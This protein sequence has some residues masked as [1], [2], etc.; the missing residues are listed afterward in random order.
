MVGH[1]ATLVRVLAAVAAI[2][3]VACSDNND[4]VG[5]DRPATGLH[6]SAS[7]GSTGSGL[8]SADLQITGS[9][10][11]GSPFTDSLFTYTLQIKNSGPDDAS[12]ATI[13][14]TLPPSVTFA[15]IG[16]VN[17]SGTPL[18]TQTPTTTSVVASCD[19]GVLR[20]GA[21]ASMQVNIYAPDGAGP[22]SNTA[23]AISSLPDPVLSNNSVAITV[24]AQVAKPAKV[25][26]VP[27][28]G[29]VAT[30]AFTTLPAEQFGGYVFAGGPS[31]VGFQF[32]PT[33][34]GTLAELIVATEASGG[35]RSEFWIYNDD[36]LNPDHVGT[37]VLGPVFGAI[38]SVFTLAAITFP[39]G[40][41]LL[42]AGQKY[43]LFGFGAAGELSGLWHDSGNVLLTTP[44]ADGPLPSIFGY[45]STCR[46]PAFEVVVLH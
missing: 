17:V 8:P 23:N 38:P 45:S 18:C 32:I 2:A 24:Q 27:A 9:A 36:P 41:P 1:S 12:H 26:P 22:I 19:F 14:D 16:L 21:S 39:N 35:G 31:G 20:K 40:G 7:G 44:C 15:E 46:Y 3:T 33:V 28:P 11:T 10:S 37:L 42:V 34:T 6:A 25:V 30:V 5:T 29:P 43:W 13:V 4:P